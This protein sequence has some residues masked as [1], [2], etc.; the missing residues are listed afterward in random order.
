M[1]RV[2]QIGHGFV[3][4]P[5]VAFF[6]TNARVLRQHRLTGLADAAITLAD[7]RGYV[8]QFVATLLTLAGIA[9]RNGIL[10]LISQRTAEQMLA[11]EGKEDLTQDIIGEISAVMGYDY[12]DPREDAG[13]AEAET[14]AKGKKPKRK[15]AVY[16]PIR[17]VLFSS[18]IVQ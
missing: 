5:D 9:I 8:R 11:V 2:D 13:A 7:C 1:R 15:R 17:G 10:M 4:N 16:N 12:E 14:P 6:E 18:F 3:E